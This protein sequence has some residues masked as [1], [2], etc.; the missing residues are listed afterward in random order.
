MK[1]ETIQGAHAL[2]NTALKMLQEESF[3][4]VQRELAAASTI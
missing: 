3:Q 4:L 2:C 1:H